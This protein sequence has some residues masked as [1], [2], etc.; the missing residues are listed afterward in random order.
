MTGFLKNF[1]PV[2]ILL[3]LATLSPAQSR[4]DGTN[5]SLP[6]FAGQDSL[7]PTAPISPQPNNS[8][9]EL[10]APIFYD[11][12][13]IDNYVDSRLTVL[14]GDAVVK[15]KGMTLEAGKITVDWN[16]HLLTAEALPDSLALPDTTSETN[17]LPRPASDSIPPGREKIARGLPIFSDGSDR[18]TGE[19]MEFNFE[20]EKGRVTRG[21]TE[22]EDGKYSGQQI[23]RLTGNTLN[24]SH[25]VFT[26]CDLAQDPHFHFSSRRMKIMVNDKVVA[27]PIIMYLGKIPVA[28]LPFG[29]FPT[30]PGRHSG[31]IVP[32][33][34]QSIRE[35]RYLRELGYYWAASEYWDAR[36]TVDYYDRSG[37]FAKAGVDY[38]WRYHFFGRLSG[39]LTRR[40][41]ADGINERRWDMAV[42]HS[43]NLGATARLSASGFF[44]SDNSFYRDFSFNQDQRLTRRLRSLAT[45]NKSWPEAKNNISINVSEERDLEDG[46]LQRLLPQ[47][48]FYYGQRQIFGGGSGSVKAGGSSQRQSEDRRWYENIY[49]DF[50]STANNTQTKRV[51]TVTADSTVTTEDTK[52]SASHRFNLRLNSPKKYF[53]WLFLSQG[54]NLSEDWFDRTTE[55]DQDDSTRAIASRVE[56]GFAARH[57]FSYSATA[58]T[59]IYGTFAPRLG[60]VK[61]LRHVVSPFVSFSYQ[62][63]FSDPKWGYYEEFVNASGATDRRDRFGGTPRGKRS[64]LTL[65]LQNL[66][67]MKTGP[68]D[69]E[70]KIDLFNL[71]F[72]TGY[73]FAAKEFR[74]SDLNT[75]FRANPS[76]NVSI[77]MGATHSFYVYDTAQSKVINR[78]LFKEHGFFSKEMLRLT[79]FRLDASLRL[80]GRTTTTPQASTEIADEEGLQTGGAGVS[81]RFE[82]DDILSDTGIP[83]RASLSFSYNLS[84]FNPAKPVKTIYLTLSNAEVRL[85]KNWRIGLSGHMDLQAKQVVSQSYSFYRD[86]HCWEAQ[87]R[88]TPGGPYEGFYF[89]ISIKSPTLRDVKYEHRGGRSSIF[90]GIY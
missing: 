1:I 9:G 46:S 21:R 34:G 78:L 45:F 5:S 53:G 2:P 89:R 67:Q 86:L 76:Q 58:N 42:S 4:L 61:A 56:R 66:F 90:G 88:W 20:T 31:L 62:P 33:F 13:L 55:Y 80:Q 82:S 84:K 12:H 3:V 49:I 14:I 73:N 60:P 36:M 29:V 15:Y 47:V 16:R 72:S 77:N 17:S 43:Q 48:S 35:G 18:M 38:A 28:V 11:A 26:T 50:S 52:R 65:Q 59:K 25:G 24:V 57:I 39:S 51:T 8:D 81:N 74:L 85:T 7:S 68:D 22:F 19:M 44:V 32:R 37:W 6:R 69:K 40:S 71:D 87:L 83:W 30:R 79:S 27:R 10:D 23:K 54:V 41:F 75:S 64:S 63:D 70:K